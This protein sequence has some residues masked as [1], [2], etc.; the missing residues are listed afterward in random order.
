MS[1]SRRFRVVAAMAAMAGMLASPAA[2][3]QRAAVDPVNPTCPPNPNWSAYPTMRFTVQ[4]VNG[5]RVLLA[6]GQVDSGLIPRL[7]AALRDETIEEIWLRSPGGDARIGNQ[8]GTLIR[9]SG[10]PTRIPA[11]WA[12][13]SACNFLFMGG[14]ARFVD[15]GGLFIVHMFT[16]TSNRDVIRQARNEGDDSTVGLIGEVEQ[17]SAQLASEDNDF[18]IRMGLYRTLLTEIMYRQSAVGEGQ[19]R[20]TRRCLTQ[21]ELRRYN[22]VNTGG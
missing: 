17:Q 12:C 21:A 15:P 19:N 22:V 10:F 5:H 11:G 2:Q 4:N 16:F 9:R 18:L 8:A 7:Q 6:E 14:A 13:F 1:A 3:A 20:S